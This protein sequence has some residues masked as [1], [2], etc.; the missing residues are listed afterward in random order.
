M[1]PPNTRRTGFSKRAQ[2][3]TFFGYLAAMAG[4]L[5]GAAV[6]LFS[7][8][9]KDAFTGVR[10]MASD[11]VAPAGMAVSAGR[12]GVHDV[13]T[14]IYGWFTWGSTN[15]RMKRE[16]EL[17]R[18]RLVEARAIEEENGRLKALLAMRQDMT[19]K[20]LQPVTSARLINS[21]ASSMRRFATISAGRDK[22][23]VT[24]MPVRSPL[25]LIGRVLETGEHTARVLLIT[26]P[27]SVVP[28][29]RANDGLAA[30]VQGHGD[31]TLL[32]RLISLGINPLKPGDVFVTSGSGGLYHPNT[33]VA[34]VMRVTRDGAVARV[35]SDPS[36]SE[37]VM[38]EP[39]FA[40]AAG[41]PQAL[42]P[43]SDAAL[44]TAPKTKAKPK[45]DQREATD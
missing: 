20:G 6:L 5:V 18:V 37:F 8:L 44:G 11:V 33:A 3:G 19:A 10:G 40:V 34:A 9:N 31:G 16:L 39:V 45:P 13:G 1:A 22:G 21:T 26:D 4:V 42:V 25:G 7:I 41:M 32:V 24:G 29:R 38:V 15:A 2:Y 23:V 17:A 28:V 27:E 36:T 43:V 12:E 35:L 14:T 30:F